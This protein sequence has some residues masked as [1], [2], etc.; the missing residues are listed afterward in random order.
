M[1]QKAEPVVSLFKKTD[2]LKK[3]FHNY[4]S[5]II[6]LILVIIVIVA[7]LL[8]E[9]SRN[10]KQVVFIVNGTKYSQ[11]DINK[12]IAYP[13]NQ[14]ISDRNSLSMVAFNYYKNIA[15]A[16]QLGIGLSNNEI[17]Q[18]IPTITVPKASTAEKDSP[19]IALTAY[20]SGIQQELLSRSLSSYSGY[21]YVFYFAQHIQT[22]LIPSTI[23]NMGNAQAIA[24]D[25]SYAQNKANYYYNQLK[26]KA[27]TPAQILTA[28]K[29][30]PKL[31]DSYLLDSCQSVHFQ[32][33][34]ASNFS[35]SYAEQLTGSP[36]IVSFVSQ[37]TSA[38]LSPIKT[39]QVAVVTSASE[40]SKDYKYINA[41]YYF[42]DLQSAHHVPSNV[43]QLFQEDVKKI[44]A[45]YYGWSK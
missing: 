20:N 17:N 14:K 5:L 26:S 8:I 19:W 6:V 27:M 44:S 22:G 21:A 16:K 36:D 12:L 9:N 11:S 4:R 18:L 3:V 37:S 24:E 43:K 40:S 33:T 41:Y 38:G 39:G 42:V 35:D 45:T 32:T 7:G 15:V 31:C 28:V 29:S 13:L 1:T 25:K 23:P 10:H 2:K 30:D 34:R